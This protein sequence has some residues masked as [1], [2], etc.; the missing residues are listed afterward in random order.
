MTSTVAIAEAA[1]PTGLSADEAARRLAAEGPNTVGIERG[2]HWAGILAAQFRSPLVLVLVAAAAISHL[3]G[4]RV[5]TGVILA[6]VAVNVAA[7]PAAL[8]G[9]G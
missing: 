9:S 7:A 3:L 2:R 5:E 6:L 4:E 1:P 8:A